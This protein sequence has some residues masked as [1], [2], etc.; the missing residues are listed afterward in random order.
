MNNGIFILPTISRPENV[1][2]LIESYRGVQECA[3]VVVFTWR[4]DPQF[5]A[6][7]RIE[8]PEE[9]DVLIEKE[10]Y[11][12]G[13]A[14]RRAFSYQPHADYYGFLADD[15]VFE[16]KFAE[17]LAE[18]ATPC[19]VAYPDDGLQHEKLCTHF[20]IGGDLVR[21]LGY[22]VLP[23][24]QHSGIDVAWHVVGLNADVLRYC[25]EVRYVHIHPLAGR[26]E[27]DEIY[28]YAK[29]LLEQ[30]NEVFQTWQHGKGIISDVQKAKRL[31]Y[32]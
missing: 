7:R 14:M 19:Y 26:A 2:R 20:V 11:T 16:T 21:E 27:T 18:A 31:A 9:W 1:T 32:S 3:P 10:R 22:W 17:P 6:Y 12:A 30:D 25:P 23:G 15:I 28:E 4:D 24:L 5:D 29:S 13:D 8:W